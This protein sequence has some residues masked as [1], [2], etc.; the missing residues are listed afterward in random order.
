MSIRKSIR[1]DSDR[2]GTVDLALS[3]EPIIGIAYA[4]A[5]AYAYDFS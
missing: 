5:Y 1:S 4:Y 2:I 3:A